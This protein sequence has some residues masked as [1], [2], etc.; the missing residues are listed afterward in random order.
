M[1]TIDR[2]SRTRSLARV[3]VPRAAFA[4]RRDG[5]SHPSAKRLIY[6]NI[7]FPLYVCKWGVPNLKTFYRLVFGHPIHTS[8]KSSGS[9]RNES[10]FVGK[11]T[12]LQDSLS[13]RIVWQSC[14]INFLPIFLSDIFGHLVRI[15][16]EISLSKIVCPIRVSIPWLQRHSRDHTCHARH[17]AFGTRIYGTFIHII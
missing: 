16:A 5:A 15:M 9:H 7:I 12:I 8:Q 6:S 14:R 3:R 4:S 10:R 13:C 2:S 17:I 11:T 1:Y